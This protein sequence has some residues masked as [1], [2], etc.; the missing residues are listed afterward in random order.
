MSI[1]YDIDSSK[2]YD[3]RDDFNFVMVNFPSFDGDIPRSPSYGFNILQLI[4]FVKVC[5]NVSDFNNR[6][7]LFITKLLKKSIDQIKVVK[8]FLNSNT[9]TRTV[10]V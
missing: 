8:L 5:S 7:R 2:M 1:T 9:D 3:K 4:P 10:L 6:N